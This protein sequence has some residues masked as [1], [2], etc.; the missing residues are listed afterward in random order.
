V[1]V[2]DDRA[3]DRELLVTVLGYVG[4]AVH[5]AASG[6]AALEF[7]RAGAPDLIIA[8]ILMPSMDGYELVRELRSD[9][10]GAQIPVIFCT[11]TYGQEEVRRLAH[12]CGVSQVMVKPCEPQQI[13]QVVAEVLA[14]ERE[15]PPPLP[16][17]ELHRQHLRVLNAKLLQKV[18]ELESAK[19]KTAESLTLLETLQ[20]ASPVGFGF[21]DRDF[22]MVRVNDTLAAVNRVPREEQ[23]GRT[24]AEVVPALWPQLEPLYRDVLQTGTAI[25]NPEISGA[26]ILRPNRRRTG[27]RATTPCD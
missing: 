21:V 11:A 14:A 24:V 3:T 5:E 16:T 2:V 1:L 6:Q 26:P 7:V 23:L 15:I 19:R 25:V 22:R 20:S 27:W 8:E 12:A 13:I 10:V 17:E 18:E 4:Y 9:P